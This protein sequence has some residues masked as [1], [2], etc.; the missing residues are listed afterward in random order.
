M[1]RMLVVAGILSA[2]IAGA[3]VGTHSA[4][5]SAASQ[6]APLEAPVGA[7]LLPGLG[8]YD[9]KI[10]TRNPEVQRWFNQGLM[11]TF[12]FNHDAAERSF[13]KAAQLDP[14]CAMAYWGLARCGMN[15]FAS[16][17]RS[18]E[19]ELKRYRDFLKEAVRRKGSVS[20]REK[21]PN[22]RSTR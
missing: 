3:W 4:R 9:F 8:N 20:E 5:V 22:A 12:G 21:R 11:L 7:A 6:P 1:K 16:R 2:V 15:W 14:D 10:T 17:G 19:P 18:S 13:L